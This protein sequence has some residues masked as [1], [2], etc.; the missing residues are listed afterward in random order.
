MPRRP[1]PTTPQSANLSSEQMRAAL[2]S[3]ERR[4]AELQAL[5]PRTVQRFGDEAFDQVRLRIE[6]TLVDIFGH[7]TIEYRRFEVDSLYAGAFYVGGIDPHELIE[8]YERGKGNAISKLQ[9]VISIFNEKLDGLG[10]T[11]GSRAIR[12]AGAADFHPE[13]QRAAGELFRNGH[14]ANAVEDACKALDGFVKFR[15]GRSDLSGTDLMNTVFSSKN[16]ILKFNDG[17]ST[18]D[19]SEQQGMMHLFAGAML[20]F[21]NPRAHQIVTDDPENTSEIL[22]FLSFLAKAADQANR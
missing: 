11:A 4:L 19:T 13:I 2:P 6:Q 20:A 16:P 22:S 21:R 5:D 7:D 14:Y 9:T 15:S 12:E 17:A 8:G 18:S 10:E 1:Q 3:L